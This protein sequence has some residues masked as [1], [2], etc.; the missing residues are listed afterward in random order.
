VELLLDWAARSKAVL[1]G[2]VEV[3]ATFDEDD[4]Q[5]F[6]RGGRDAIVCRVWL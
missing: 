2:A 3:E 4:S 1:L 5:G 6:G